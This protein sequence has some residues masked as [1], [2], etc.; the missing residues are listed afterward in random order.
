MLPATHPV[1][2]A[3]P[4]L[5]VELDEAVEPSVEQATAAPGEEAM[6]VVGIGASHSGHPV[7][8]T[9]TQNCT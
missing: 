3:H 1:V 6:I 9:Q 4:E 5:F 2:K 7:L 8:T